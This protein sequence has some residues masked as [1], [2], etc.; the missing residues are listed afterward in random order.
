MLR[1]LAHEALGMQE[2]PRIKNVLALGLEAY[3]HE[4]E[5]AL[6]RIYTGRSSA[7]VPRRVMLYS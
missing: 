4:H 5:P 7:G 2:V 3:N 6:T 1:R